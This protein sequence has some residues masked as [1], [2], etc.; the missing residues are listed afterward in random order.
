MT[1]GSATVPDPLRPLHRHDV[2]GYELPLSRELA[3]SRFSNEAPVTAPGTPPVLSLARIRRTPPRR[4]SP[5]PSRPP[6]AST[7][8]E[9]VGAGK[10]SLFDGCV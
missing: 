1:H 2:G 6:S 9:G 4:S 3:A 7:S 5:A 8:G 10:V